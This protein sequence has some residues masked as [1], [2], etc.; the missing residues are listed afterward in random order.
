MV[1][2]VFYNQ[3]KIEEVMT[4][5]G[6]TDE[7]VIELALGID[8]NTMDGAQE[9][10]EQGISYAY[11]DDSGNYLYDFENMQVVWQ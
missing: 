1:A 4:D 5:H 6:M 3:K 8:L 7:E 11:L 2:E 10:Y 9:A